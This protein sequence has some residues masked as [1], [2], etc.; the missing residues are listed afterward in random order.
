M[1]YQFE[2]CPA[3]LVHICLDTPHPTRHATGPDDFG[4]QATCWLNLKRRGHRID[5]TYEDGVFGQWAGRH[6]DKY[7]VVIKKLLGGPAGFVEYD[8]LEEVHATWELD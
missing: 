7:V 1:P 4:D 8:T 3:R 5:D 2:T 6:G